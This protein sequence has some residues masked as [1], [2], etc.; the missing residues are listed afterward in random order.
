MNKRTAHTQPLRNAADSSKACTRPR[1]SKRASGRLGGYA[2]QCQKK[3]G[4]WLLFSRYE[5]KDE[6]EQVRACLT[7]LGQ[8]TRIVAAA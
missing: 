6:A 2:V 4:S 5:T 1:E 3:N 8:P 7:A